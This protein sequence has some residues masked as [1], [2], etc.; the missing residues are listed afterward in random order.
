[1]SIMMQSMTQQCNALS[2]VIGI[3]LHSCNAPAKVI[4][5]L[6]RIGVSISMQSVNNAIRALSKDAKR[7]MQEMGQSLTIGYVYDNFDVDF[8]TSISTVEK[9]VDT[10]A[11]MMSADAFWLQ[12]C[13]LEDLKCSDQLWHRSPF[14]DRKDDHSA[15]Q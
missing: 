3:F 13:I 5:T 11:H 9:S 1:M 12:Q 6:A 4:K 15:P 8:L 2:S 10:L 14:N 7:W